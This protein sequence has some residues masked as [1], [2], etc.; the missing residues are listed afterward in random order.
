MRRD[1][2][3]NLNGLWDY[4][5]T[6]IDAEQ[7]DNWDGEILIPFAIE[8]PLSG[9][10]KRLTADQAL[11][12][13]TE[14]STEQISAL[15]L[16]DGEQV[17]LHF[18]AV[19]YQCEVWLDG[20]S[21]GKHTGGNLPFS[22]LI[23]CSKPGAKHELI[24]RVVDATDAIG[25]YQLRGKQ[26]VKNRGI[27]YTPVSG[28]WQ[29]VWM[30][31]APAKHIENISVRG[32]MNGKVTVSANIVGDASGLRVTRMPS[33][34]RKQVSPVVA[35]LDGNQ[36]A[37]LEFEISDPKLWSPESPTLYDLRIELLD[38]ENIVDSVQSYVGLRSVGKTR[39]TD[40]NLRL[41]LNGELIFHWGPLDQGWWPGGLLTPPSDEAIKF[42]IDYLKRAGFNMIRK[43]IKIEPRR[44]YAHCDRIGMMVWQDQIEG[45]A[46]FNSGEWPVWKRLGK[47]HPQV[48][49][50]NHWKPGQPVDANWPDWAHDQYM[51]ELKGMVD[52]LD[53]HPSI[54]TWVPFNE[55][56]GQH[57]TMDVGKWITQYDPSRL[58][59]IASGGNFFAVGD[60][61]DEHVYPHPDFDVDDPRYDDYAKI[62]GEFGGHG[63]PVPGHLWDQKK[64]N[65][66]Y[67]G[68][69]KSKQEYIERY[70]ESI[71]RLGDLKKRGVAGGVYTQTTDVEGEINGLMTYDREVIKISAGHLRQMAE[72]AG[73]IEKPVRVSQR[74]NV[75]IILVDDMGYSDIGCYGSEIKTPNIDALAAT[76]LRFTQF[77][78]QG[79]CCPTRASLITGLQPHQAGIGHMTLPPRK[80]LGIT[81]AYQGFLND[82]CTTIAEVLKSSGYRTAM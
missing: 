49:K 5:V 77:Y 8:A 38:G 36:N 30:E 63:W 80:T 79:R 53:I 57:R 43:H 9:V 14:L 54:V 15:K 82:N 32:D 66:G 67:G 22:F 12:Y 13:R 26:R 69:P 4:A 76:G 28:I 70:R 50:P 25:K 17:R 3:V 6:P 45:G 23:D 81:G 58:I 65:W 37:T 34:S 20:T 21:L 10:G 62:V 56:W 74:P 48:S 61:A 31:P 47:D 29:T 24:V 7:P 73:L 72:D 42:E 46:G 1:R 60:M 41:T 11:W 75:I 78:N 39:D 35:S 59:N 51:T 64:R 44:Y 40:G 68:L 16:R 19:D 55:R 71:N 2:W 33:E 27:F 52:H 18:E